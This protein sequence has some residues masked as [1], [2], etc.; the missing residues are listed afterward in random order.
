MSSYRLT[1]DGGLRTISAAVPNGRTAACWLTLTPDGR[2]AYASNT[3]DGTVSLYAVGENGALT[4]LEGAE[5][6]RPAREGLPTSGPTDT[7]ISADG[8]FFYQQY[9]GLGVVGAY[10]VGPGGHL[11]PIPGGDGEGLPALGAQGLAGF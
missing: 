7:A 1:E 10:R 4:L 11:T 8:Q 5:V 9:G 2:Y 6:S 3:G